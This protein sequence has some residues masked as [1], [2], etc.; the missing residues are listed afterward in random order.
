MKRM[1][2]MKESPLHDLHGKIVSI[3]TQDSCVNPCQHL[4][5]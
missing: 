1:K 5:P 3:Y 2:D 4:C